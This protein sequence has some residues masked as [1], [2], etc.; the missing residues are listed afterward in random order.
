MPASRT[1]LLLSL[2][3]CGCT[4]QAG[5]LTVESEHVTTTC[6][7]AQVTLG[8][9]RATIDWPESQVSTAT[10]VTIGVIAQPAAG[11]A[12]DRAHCSDSE[13]AHVSQGFWDTLIHAL[14]AVGAILPAF[15]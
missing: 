8:Q 5:R 6:E 3:L 12:P 11:S 1:L 4:F 2:A 7:F 13:S 9:A 14:A 10:Q 15:L